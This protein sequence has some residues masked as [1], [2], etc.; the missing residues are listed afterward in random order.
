LQQLRAIVVADS[1]WSGGDQG[2]KDA[3]NEKVFP[4]DNPLVDAVLDRNADLVLVVVVVG[5]IDVSVSGL[6]VEKQVQF[7]CMW[8]HGEG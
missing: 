1:A 3:L 2:R 4:G 6:H 5:G 7:R 8:E